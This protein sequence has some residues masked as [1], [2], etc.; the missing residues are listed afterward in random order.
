M[1]FVFLSS[2]S[3][4]FVSFVFVSIFQLTKF[5]L[6]LARAGAGRLG[7]A[8]RSAHRGPQPWPMIE[9]R[10]SFFR[11]M[12]SSEMIGKRSQTIRNNAKTSRNGPKMIQNGPK[13]RKTVQKRCETVRKLCKTMRKRS[14][15]G[16]REHPESLIRR[17]GGAMCRLFPTNIK[18]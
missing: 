5:K 2:F 16:L 13:R 3:F 8:W 6:Q 14:W 7:S 15:D 12:E 10:F 18:W 1:A 4:R 11:G 9:I 17:R